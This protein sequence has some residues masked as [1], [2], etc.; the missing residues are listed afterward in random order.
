M[1]ALL[2]MILM[3]GAGLKDAGAQ[4]VS[5]SPKMFKQKCEVLHGIMIDVRTPEEY[6][7]STIPG[8]ININMMA[9]DFKKQIEKLNKTK[10]YFLFCGTGM[11]SG[12]AVE[13]MK[14]AGFLKVFDLEGGM[15]SWERYDLPID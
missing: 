2:L 11:R 12:E 3:I 15:T 9:P 6:L 14:K 13:E 4:T 5:L 10:A 8:A 7:E 1:K